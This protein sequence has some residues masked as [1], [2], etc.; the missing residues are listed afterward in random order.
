VVKTILIQAV[1]SIGLIFGLRIGI[2]EPSFVV[3]REIDGV[4]IRRYQARTA[5]ETTVM[6]DEESARSEG[7][8]RLARYIFGANSGK[9]KIAMTAPVAQQNGQKIA[10]T[11]PVGAQRGTGGGW[12]IRFFMPSKYQLENLPTPQDS[13]VRLVPVPAETAAVLKFSGLGS[14]DAVS[15]R[16]DQLQEVLRRNDIHTIGEP[17]TLFY[18]PPWTI[19]MFRRNEV[20]ILIDG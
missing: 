17:M 19:P 20:A 13:A 9:A 10:M 14:P 12:V 15:A 7:F 8:R 16:I 4:Q 3:L 6:A 18:D 1:E 5:A 2:E 11:A